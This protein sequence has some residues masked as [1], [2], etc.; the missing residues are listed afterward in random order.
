M[1]RKTKYCSKCGAEINLD[2]EFCPKCGARVGTVLHQSSSA[3]I[4]YSVPRR[5]IVLVYILG[6]VTFGIYFLYWM[7]K[8]KHEIND[9]GANIPTSI[10]LFIPIANIY[11]LYRYS[12][13]FSMYVKKDDNSLLW[14]IVFF[15]IGPVMPAIVQSELNRLAS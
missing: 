13:G 6:I 9:I 2:A 7:Y 1:E 3:P 14:F 10:L 15:L 11:W 12:E 8:T 5:N 4:I